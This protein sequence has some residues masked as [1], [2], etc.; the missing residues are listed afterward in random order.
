MS[1]TALTPDRLSCL[2]DRQVY[3]SGKTC[4]WRI[5]QG[6]SS[7]VTLSEVSPHRHAVGDWAADADTN[8]AKVPWIESEV[9]KLTG[10]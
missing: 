7:W 1:T 10:H 9:D 2:R 3:N 4:H 5:E 6:T 8:L